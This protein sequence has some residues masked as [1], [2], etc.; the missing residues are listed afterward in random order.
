MHVKIKYFQEGKTGEDVDCHACYMA[1]VNGP[2]KL[3]CKDERTSGSLDKF[4]PGHM[5]GLLFGK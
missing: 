2:R 3:L 5:T 1:P 4:L